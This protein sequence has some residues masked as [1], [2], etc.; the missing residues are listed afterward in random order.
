MIRE[1]N[2]EKKLSFVWEIRLLLQDTV[3]GT[4]CVNLYVNAKSCEYASDRMWSEKAG[5]ENNAKAIRAP[6]TKV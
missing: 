1:Y 3:T 6:F 2:G 4:C 5:G